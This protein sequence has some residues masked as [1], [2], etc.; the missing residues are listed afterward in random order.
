MFRDAILLFVQMVVI[1]WDGILGVAQDEESAWKMN[2]VNA[3]D[4]DGPPGWKVGLYADYLV[5]IQAI[6]PSIVRG[7][8]TREGRDEIPGELGA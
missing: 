1:G 2:L 5:P 3:R 6:D 4:I 7:G 8:K